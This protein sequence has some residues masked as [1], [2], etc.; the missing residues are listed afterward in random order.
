MHQRTWVN[1]N[2]RIFSFLF[3]SPTLKLLQ[4]NT[5]NLHVQKSNPWIILCNYIN[6]IGLLSELLLLLFVNLQ[7]QVDPC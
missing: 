1:F 4:Q 6:L 5:L 2:L 3:S 7:I